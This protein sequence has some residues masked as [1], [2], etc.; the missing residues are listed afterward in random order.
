VVAA[1]VATYVMAHNRLHRQEI[2]V[3]EA[4]AGVDVQLTR[5]ADLIPNLVS[6]VKGYL[7]HERGVLAELT[8]ARAG[9]RRAVEAGSVEDRAQ[10][11]HRLD[12]AV[13]GILVVAEDYPELRASDT[14]VK[15]Q[16]QL[17]AT[18]DQVALAREYYNS[19]VR[20]LNTSLAT[21]PWTF[22]A[23]AAGVSRRD[24]FE[25]PAAVEAPPTVQF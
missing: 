22:F 11:G 7:A 5:R 1:L 8:D 16:Q 19:A 2:A 6:T 12:R 23:G 25:A 21:V 13:G 20:A 4:L 24:F 14:F 3:E 15:L 18:E 17:A 9:V 10:A